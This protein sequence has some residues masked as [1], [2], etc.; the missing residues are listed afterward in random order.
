MCHGY[1]SAIS[2]AIADYGTTKTI[3]VR[4]PS[5]YGY[6]WCTDIVVVRTSFCKETLF[7]MI[8]GLS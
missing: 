4:T 8:V 5:S 3:V 6:I 2:F 1:N 7:V